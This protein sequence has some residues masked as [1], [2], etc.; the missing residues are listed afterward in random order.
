MVWPVV[1]IEFENDRG[2]HDI[3]TRMTSSWHDIILF[4][5]VWGREH[6]DVTA[7]KQISSPRDNISG[8]VTGWC[9]MII[10]GMTFPFDC[11]SSDIIAKGDNM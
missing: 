6:P 1:L 11:H 4:L 2:G 10:I 7:A 8:S 3:I 9:R 5:I